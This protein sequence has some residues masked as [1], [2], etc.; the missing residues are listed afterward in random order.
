M[1]SNLPSTDTN[2]K[3]VFDFGI[4][5]YDAPLD[6]S[7]NNDDELPGKS[8]PTET[9][10]FDLEYYLNYPS[11]ETNLLSTSVLPGDPNRPSPG[12]SPESF[13][14]DVVADSLPSDEKNPS[15]RSDYYDEKIIGSPIMKNSIPDIWPAEDTGAYVSHTELPEPSSNEKSI[16]NYLNSLGNSWSGLVIEDMSDPRGFPSEDF[17]EQVNYIK[18][19]GEI[20][21]NGYTMLSTTKVATNIPLVK[22]L[23]TEFIKEH[24]KKNI[25]KRHI[26]HFLQ[27][28]NL[29]QYLSSDIIRFLKHEH[30]IFIPDVLDSFPVITA[31]SDP[32]NK[33]WLHTI[34]NDLIDME[35]ENLHV[36]AVSA[37][38]RTCVAN[39]AKAIALLESSHG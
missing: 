36:P 13:T 2:N 30:D 10:F 32:S 9:T 18:S 38:L 22:E 29:P 4:G 12:P 5:T 27:E 17:S 11:S 26:L 3:R 21:P 25:V 14:K 6:S 19:D 23:S 39:I 7:S 24:G 1:S 15:A 8:T 33:I 31:S 28:K 37:Q 35:I 20:Q 34:W 16:D